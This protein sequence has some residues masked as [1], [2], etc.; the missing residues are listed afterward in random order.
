M[1]EDTFDVNENEGEKTLLLTPF[2]NCAV[3]VM[4]PEVILR[5]TF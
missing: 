5:W 4:T 2:G 3:P 1:E